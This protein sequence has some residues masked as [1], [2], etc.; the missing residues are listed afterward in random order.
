[1][2]NTLKVLKKE[3]ATIVDDTLKELKALKKE[4]ASIFARLDRDPINNHDALDSAYEDLQRVRKD[5][6]YHEDLV[7]L[8]EKKKINRKFLPVGEIREVLS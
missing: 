2:D 8:E 5:I 1:M 3:A 7:E 6:S 4:A